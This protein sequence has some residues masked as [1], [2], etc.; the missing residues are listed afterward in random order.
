MYA[1]AKCSS[2]AVTK[3]RG[4]Y[5]SFVAT[6]IVLIKC[7]QVLYQFELEVRIDK[8]EIIILEPFFFNLLR[9][10]FP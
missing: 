4:A 8:N 9:N 2:I 6:R 5:N 7:Y 1:V 10:N 3:F